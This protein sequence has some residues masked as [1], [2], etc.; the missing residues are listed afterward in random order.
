[1]TVEDALRNGLAASIAG[2]SFALD[3][4]VSVDTNRVVALQLA[5]DTYLNAD[6]EYIVGAAEVFLHFLQ[7]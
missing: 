1:M 4:P 2:L 6:P 3:K 7:A 5:T